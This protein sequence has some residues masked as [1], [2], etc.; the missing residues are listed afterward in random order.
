MNE[1]TGG[2]NTQCVHNMRDSIRNLPRSN[3]IEEL[4]LD[5]LSKNQA[6]QLLVEGLID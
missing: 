2:L 6:L 3:N 4:G 1:N 5:H